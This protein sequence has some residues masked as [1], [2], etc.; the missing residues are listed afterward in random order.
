MTQVAIHPEVPPIAKGWITS[1]RDLGLVGV[2]VE[3]FGD[4]GAGVK[5]VGGFGVDW[6]I[7]GYQIISK[8]K[9]TIFRVRSFSIA[10][11]LSFQ[12]PIR[13]L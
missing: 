1:A 9:N 5:A 13:V 7:I 12:S 6:D 10:G 8:E 3:G 4:G 11:R 2:G